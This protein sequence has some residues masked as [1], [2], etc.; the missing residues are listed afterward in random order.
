MTL[1]RRL[2]VS[3]HDVAGKQWD[4]ICPGSVDTQS[5]MITGLSAYGNSGCCPGFVEMQFFEG[6]TEYIHKPYVIT[7]LM[8][9]LE[10][11]YMT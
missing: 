6:K 11:H 9:Y 10:K 7:H 8:I 2:G 3:R 1:A 4:N 5:V